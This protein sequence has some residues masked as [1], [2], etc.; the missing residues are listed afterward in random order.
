MAEPS[1]T[2]GHELE[3]LAD[4]EW[5]RSNPAGALDLRHKA[6]AAYVAERSEADAGMVA[7]RLAVEHFLRG[8]HSVGAGFLAR[9]HRHVDDLPEGGAIAF[10]MMIEANVARF[11]GDVDRSLAL[12]DRAIAIARAHGRPDVVAMAIHN[13]G[14]V[15]IDA[16]RVAEGIPYLDE[17]MASVLAGG[18]DPFWTGI[19]YCDVIAACLELG[20]VRRAGEWS[21]AAMAWC[22]T[23]TPDAP[24]QGMCR[25]NRAEVA[26]LR[27]AW[28]E[29]EAEATLAT[30][31]LAGLEP[32]LVASAF[33]QVGEIRRV[34]G[35]LAGAEAA[36]ERA[37]ELGADPEP[38]LG[39]VRLAQR[40]FEAAMSALRLALSREERPPR[41]VRL[42]AA[43]VE[44]ALA[45]GELEVA[46]VAAAE[47]DVVVT[48]IR[49]P[50]LD[51]VAATVR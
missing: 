21:D 35:D 20:D 10:V 4:A 25:V 41:R 50:A 18:I 3:A 15:L 1:V 47:L 7:A 48:A 5:W 24:Y 12:A 8:E 30:T 40:K 2:T 23:L 9:A 34:F 22:E 14:L 44:A 38:G 16:G 11:A 45:A 32:S 28:A 31:E 33:Q 39:L 42:L 51:A 43:Q 27:G 17:A 13:R 46:R 19:I 26:R 49:T 36:F 29:A 37:Q 6:Y